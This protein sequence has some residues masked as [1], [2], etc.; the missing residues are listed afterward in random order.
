MNNRSTIIYTMNTPG[1]KY[2]IVKGEM[3]K[4][5]IISKKTHPIA[6]VNEY[7]KKLINTKKLLDKG[8]YYVLKETIKVG[9]LMAYNLHTGELEQN[10]DS[11]NDIIINHNDKKIIDEF[12][13]DNVYS[14]D[15]ILRNN[16]YKDS[17][18][19]DSIY[20]ISVNF[21]TLSNQNPDEFS[22][23]EKLFYN[24]LIDEKIIYSD[25]RHGKTE[26]KECDIVDE[27][28][29]IQIE[30]VTEFKNRI[31]QDKTP[32]RNIELF[33]IEMVDNNLIH[34]SKAILK[35]F[36]EKTY[37]NKYNKQIG[38]FCFGNQKSVK[39]MLEKLKENIKGKNVKN[40]FSA[41][42]IIWYDCIYDE[43]YFYNSNGKIK[44]LNNIKTKIVCKKKIQFE[45]MQN[46]HKYLLVLKNVFKS[47]SAVSYLTKEDIIDH[48]KNLNIKTGD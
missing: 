27:K 14:T 2:H 15:A 7:K 5:S 32:H 45:D 6:I 31:K 34:S 4:G 39:I 23:V 42:Y 25:S 19:I 11:K 9:A 37:T 46:N 24:V 43:Y 12:G 35:K 3:K 47:E 48:L 16:E 8:E 26:N 40:D 22:E 28:K 41:I 13:I 36:F 21:D 30:I 10:I 1:F 33:M 17:M 29:N 18:L 38:V 20:E 44:K